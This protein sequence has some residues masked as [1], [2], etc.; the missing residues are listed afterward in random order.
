[1]AITK[2]SGNSVTAAAKGDLVVGSATNDAAVLGVGAN[3]TVLTAASGEATGLQWA[4]P[5]AA[6]P[7]YTQLASVSL[8]GSTTTVSG[9]SGVNNIFF[10]I[11]NVSSTAANFEFSFILNGATSGY[12]YQ[13]FR[14]NFDSSLTLTNE[15]GDSVS[16]FTL[17]QGG[18]SAANEGRASGQIFGCNSSG[19][20]VASYISR[21][22]GSTTNKSVVING[23]YDSASTISSIAFKT[24][25]GTFDSGTLKVYGA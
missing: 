7:N 8:S 16:A 15:T 24:A 11:N 3:G 12:S 19:V 14:I 18:G 17:G 10:I 25:Q 5:T 9:I 6:A 22:E 23:F 21:F 2:A 4:T 20:K 1:M 13:G